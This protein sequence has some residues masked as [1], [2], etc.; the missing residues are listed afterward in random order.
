[1]QRKLKLRNGKAKVAIS[2]ERDGHAGSSGS[3]RSS[4]GLDDAIQKEADKDA[5]ARRKVRILPALSTLKRVDLLRVARQYEI[6]LP[7]PEHMTVEQLRSYLYKEG[8]RLSDARDPGETKITFGKYQKMGTTF[9][10]LSQRDPEYCGWILREAKHT[11][12][13]MDEFRSYLLE[14]GATGP[15]RKEGSRKP[16][17]SSESEVNTNSDSDEPSQ[18][19]AV[20]RGRKRGARSKCAASSAS[21]RSRSMSWE[22][23]APSPTDY[24]HAIG[25]CLNHLLSRIE[26]HPRANNTTPRA[27]HTLRALFQ[28]ITQEADERTTPA[29][30]R[31]WMNSDPKMSQVMELV[32]KF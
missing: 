6:E 4:R 15:R 28:A 11:N 32:G 8:E 26:A 24:S 23:L 7:D 19:A 12:K 14:V 27:T 31:D 25:N 17:S 13:N 21:A 9:K 10:E 1:M 22:N 5:K 3:N 2:Y 20:T 30:M 16:P 29:E 18:P